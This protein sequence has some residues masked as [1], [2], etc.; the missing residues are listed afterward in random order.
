LFEEESLVKRHF[1]DLERT[2]HPNENADS[3]ASCGKKLNSNT[4]VMKRR[5]DFI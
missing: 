1:K 2:D 3:M 4:S 5:G